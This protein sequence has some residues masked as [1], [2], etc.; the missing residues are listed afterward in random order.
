MTIIADEGLLP[1]W[2]DPVHD[3]QASFRC[4]LKALSEP[5]VIQQLPVQLTPAAPLAL[6]T[7]AVCLTLMDFETPV[8]LAPDVDTTALRNYLR[9]HCGAPLVAERH[10]AQF[11]VL[12]APARQH[13]VSAN[14]VSF[15]LA[16]FAQGS[17]TYPDASA[18][19]LI[20]L[21]DLD[22]G[23]Q[24]WMSGP[25]IRE[26]ASLRVSGLPEYFFTEWE[27]NHQAFPMGVDVIFCCAD[28]ILGLPRTTRIQKGDA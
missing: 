2:S 14:G 12:T 27:Q 5:G 28:K 6:A 26:R 13:E 17:L 23:P 15:S 4:V 16:D 25:G 22:N 21:D 9:F 10:R 20:Q 18:T 3:A 11:A 7:T 1:A 24:R 19:L 8:W